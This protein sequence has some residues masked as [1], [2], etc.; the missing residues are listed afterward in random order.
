MADRVNRHLQQAA[1]RVRKHVLVINRQAK[2]SLFV[3]EF[4]RDGEKNSPQ[5]G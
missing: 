2:Q 5:K 4:S 3:F 1:E